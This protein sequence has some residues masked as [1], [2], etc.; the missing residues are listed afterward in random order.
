[1]M[2]YRVELVRDFRFDPSLGRTGANLIGDEE[3]ALL[4]KLNREGRF[5]LWVGPARVRH[6]VPKDRATWA[7][8]WKYYHGLGMT[9]VRRHG[10]P[11][12]STLFGKPRWAVREYW[13]KRTG[14]WLSRQ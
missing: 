4:D 12:C 3:T 8:V 1:N 13:A 11:A 14:S 6:W 2:A 10:I 7:F 9:G 5:G